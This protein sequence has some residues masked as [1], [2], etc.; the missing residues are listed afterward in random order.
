MNRLLT[1]T[2]DHMQE[3]EKE[4]KKF[5]TGALRELQETKEILEILKNS[6]TKARVLPE[7]IMTV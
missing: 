7:Y 1:V 5:L 2:C 4:M 3:M 6:S